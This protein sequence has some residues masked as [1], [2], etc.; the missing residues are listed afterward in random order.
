MRDSLRH[1]S[2]PYLRRSMTTIFGGLACPACCR[3]SQ[4]MWWGRG[5]S[6]MCLFP[7]TSCVAQNMDDVLQRP[8]RPDQRRVGKPRL[9]FTPQWYNIP[10]L[11]HQNTMRQIKLMQ[12]KYSLEQRVVVE[13][14][15]SLLWDLLPAQSV[16]PPLSSLRLWLLSRFS[17]YPD[18]DALFVRPHSFRSLYLQS[19]VEVSIHDFQSR[20]DPNASHQW[21]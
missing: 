17:R 9:P 11:S 15:S 16:K 21:V 18:T 13:V 1:Q 14:R 19:L 3:S 12:T 5:K 8:L 10:N 6:S 2:F 20:S 4:D 7:S